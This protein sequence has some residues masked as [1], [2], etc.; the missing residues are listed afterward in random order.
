[1]VGRGAAAA[2]DDVEEA[3]VGPLG[4]LLRH[5]LGRLVVAA[6]LVGQAGVGVGAD[7]HVRHP[8][9]LLDVLAELVGAQRA[10]QSEAD[11]AGVAQA[12]PEG[13][14]RLAGEGPPALV[15]DRAGDH[16]GDTT[17]GLSLEEALDGEDRGLS[18]ERVEDGLDQQQVGTA[19]QQGDGGVGVG[20]DQL[21]PAHRPE[22][23]VVD[24]RRERQRLGGR[25]EHAGDPAHPPVEGLHGLAL[26][27]GQRR[28]GLVQLDHHVLKAE[29]GQGDA[30]GVEGVG[31][32]DVGAGLQ[33]GAVDPGDDLGLRQH[34]QLV[35]ALLLVLVVAEAVP[36]VVVL[37]QAVPLDHGAHGAVQDQDPGGEGLVKCLDSRVHAF[38]P[39][40]GLT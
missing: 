37:F 22:A 20:L 36:A 21:V 40:G 28:R 9:E 25:P 2:P 11:R 38:S 5:A 4:D 39:A 8:G 29:V 16:H 30:V 26:G 3:A 13:F 18:V 19:V 6:Q 1:M 15:G 12:V 33:V 17:L 31:L 32:D 7:G 27:A 34:Q 10:V 23:R 35:V 24:I 14:G